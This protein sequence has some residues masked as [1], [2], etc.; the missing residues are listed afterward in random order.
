MTPA[1]LSAVEPRHPL[2]QRLFCYWQERRGARAFPARRDVDPVDFSYALGHV[3]LIDVAHEPLRFR[4]RLVPSTIAHYLGYETTGKNVD[5]IPEPELRA[6]LIASYTLVVNERRPL[7]SAAERNLDGRRWRY[8]VAYLPLS[9][10]GT[11]IDMLMVCRIAE[12]PRRTN[13]STVARV[14]SISVRT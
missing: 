9:S 13:P 2:L 3:S 6:C 8:E 14:D 11:T 7:F 10:D 5:A 1:A 12:P 4:F